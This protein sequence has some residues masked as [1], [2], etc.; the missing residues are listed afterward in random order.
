MHDLKKVEERF[1][2][3]LKSRLNEEIYLKNA[4]IPQPLRGWG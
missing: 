1:H 4:R 2:E 3:Y